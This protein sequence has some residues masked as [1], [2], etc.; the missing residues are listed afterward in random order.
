MKVFK[1]L[2]TIAAMLAM[3]GSASDS[4]AG[5]LGIGKFPSKEPARLPGKA[6]SSGMAGPGIAQLLLPVVV[7]GVL[8]AVFAGSSSSGH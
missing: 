1:R 5:A 8:V 2:V 4:Q 6:F 3:L 7:V